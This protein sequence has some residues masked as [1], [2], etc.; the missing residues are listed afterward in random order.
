MIYLDNNATTPL[1]PEVINKIKDFLPNY[2]NPS[3]AYEIGRSVKE[4]INS[5]RKEIAD[6]LNCQPEEII[7]TASGSEANN[8][9]LKSTLERCC[10]LGCHNKNQ[11]HIISSSIEHPSVLNTLNCLEKQNVDV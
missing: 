4:M 8:T 2:G 7:F 11:M 9:V 6:F 3:S 10:G 5:S 1:H